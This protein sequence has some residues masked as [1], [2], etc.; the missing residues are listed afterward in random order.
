MCSDQVPTGGEERM[1]AFPPLIPHDFEMRGRGNQEATADIKVSSAGNCPV[2][3]AGVEHV[4]T[5]FTPWK[6]R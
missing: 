5:S 3:R 6:E 1:K 2:G 4:K